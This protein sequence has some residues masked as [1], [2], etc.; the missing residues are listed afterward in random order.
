MFDINHKL[1]INKFHKR[2]FTKELT[3]FNIT[4]SREHT[5][6]EYMYE[7]QYFIKRCIKIKCW[8][9]YKITINL[10]QPYITEMFTNI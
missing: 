1:S 2:L 3:E 4:L 8:L 9:K 5:E 7:K 10:I 6:Y